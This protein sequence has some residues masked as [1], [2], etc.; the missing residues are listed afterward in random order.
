LPSVV[1]FDRLGVGGGGVG[2][3]E[4]NLFLTFNDLAAATAADLESTCNS[5]PAASGEFQPVDPLSI[6]NG[7]NPNG[8]WQIKVVDL[9][10][11]DGGAIVGFDLEI[12]AVLPNTTDIISVEEEVKICQNASTTFSLLIGTAYDNPVTLTAQGVPPSV[13]VTYS[14][15]PAIPGSS[16]DVTMESNN[17]P[18][19]DYSI[20]W[21]GSDGINS[22]N[23][24][25][26]LDVIGAPLSFA[27]TSP[28]NG[29]YDQPQLTD[30]QWQASP[31]A[32]SYLLEVFEQGTSIVVASQN[33]NNPEVSLI[34]DIGGKYD[35]SVTAFNDCGNVSS[36]NTWSFDVIG[37]LSFS[38]I[39]T[40]V[41]T[42]VENEFNF[43]LEVGEGYFAPAVITYSI[44]GNPS[45]NVSF[46]QDETMVQP[47][48]QVSGTMVFDASNNAG[49]YP[50]IFTI[51][52]SDHTSN[53]QMNVQI[54]APAGVFELLEP[55]NQA[56]VLMLQPDLDWGNSP[57]ADE[58]DLQVANDA[59]FTDLIVDIT[60]NSTS[61][62]FSN[63]LDVGSTYYWRVVSKNPCGEY[64]SEVFSFTIGTSAISE[65]EGVELQIVPNPFSDFVE[66]QM[67]SDLENSEKLNWNLMTS[68]GKIISAGNIS[69]TS[70]RLE[71]VDL[72]AG[73]YFIRISNQGQ[74]MVERIVK[75]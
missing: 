64:E 67:L 28:T 39:V 50:V 62:S 5:N 53:T 75:F 63:S 10:G 56:E 29:A 15:N 4:N 70:T 44:A 51:T 3:G 58:Y 25:L 61:Y 49:N 47:G 32:S 57:S 26:T 35:W 34:L 59:N 2:C 7:E 16:V 54:E 43:F 24:G 23:G 42:C 40:N 30:F 22:G 72:P 19:G 33:V 48:D 1:L 14:E 45:V 52:D 21:T 13:T 27:L 11:Q 60:L 12:C 36:M 18:I 68:D 41:N 9:A 37:D 17:T 71:T 20:A 31:D 38:S 6:F 66:I 73:M 46:N 74:Q 69:N 8:I 65:I 55:A